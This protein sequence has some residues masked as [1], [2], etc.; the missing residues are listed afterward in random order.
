MQSILAVVTGWE[1]DRSVLAA[2]LAVGRGF[3]ARIEVLHPRYDPALAIPASG[4]G[5]V[6]FSFADIMAT[7]EARTAALA[8]SAHRAFDD[9]RNAH[10]IALA[11]AADASELCTCWGE[12]IGLPEEVVALRARLTDLVVIGRPNYPEHDTSAIAETALFDSGRPVLLVPADAA[13]TLSNRMAILWNGSAQ[14]ARAV[15]DALPLL[16]K[17]ESVAV[18]SAD[19]RENSIEPSAA[20]LVDH[21]KLHGVRAEVRD[22]QHDGTAAASLLKAAIESAAGLIVMGAYGH[23]RF[24]ELVLGGVTRHMMSQSTVPVLMAR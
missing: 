22:L 20:E 15:G 11:G 6:P 14:A 5:M 24:R 16:L 1:L 13:V 19:D 18:I 4:D 10:G 21:L 8:A 12:L 9:W 2:A 7:I 17:A 3:G 23:S